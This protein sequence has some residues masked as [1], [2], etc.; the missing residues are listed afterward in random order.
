[1]PE[2]VRTVARRFEYFKTREIPESGPDFL[3]A[4]LLLLVIADLG[5]KHAQASVGYADLPGAVTIRA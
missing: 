4:A 3:R 1:M 5:N 2:S